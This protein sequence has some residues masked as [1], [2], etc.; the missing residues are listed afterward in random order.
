VLVLAVV[1]AVLLVACAAITAAKGKWV[2]LVLGLVL[3]PAWIVGAIRLAKPNSVWEKRFYTESKRMRA[4]ERAARPG[5]GGF[6]TAA[7]AV[8]GLLLFIGSLLAL[9]SYRIGSAAMEPTLLCERPHAG[10]S[11]SEADRIAA[12]RLFL[13][14]DPGRGDIVSFKMPETAASICGSDGVFVKRVIGLPGDSIEIRDGVVFANGSQLDEP[15]VDSVS[16]GQGST[17]AMTVPED[18]Y[19]L[20]GDKRDFS[21]D[22]RQFGALPRDAV[23]AKVVFRYWPFSRLGIP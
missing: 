19:F 17:A 4:E 20:M 16:R 6:V 21:C 2:T 23:I 14:G 10:C 8:L 5:I 13:I 18:S 1:W 22:S 3:F 9:K 11:A 15:Y 12:V 7:A